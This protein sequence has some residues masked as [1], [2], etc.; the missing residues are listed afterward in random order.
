LLRSWLLELTLAALDNNPTMD[1]IAPWVDVV[2]RSREP[3]SDRF[4]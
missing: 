1:G 3:E 2:E 4:K